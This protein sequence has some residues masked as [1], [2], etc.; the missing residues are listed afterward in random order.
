MLIIIGPID[1]LTPSFAIHYSINDAL[2]W[3]WLLIAERENIVRNKL[4]FLVRSVFEADIDFL[5]ALSSTRT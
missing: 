2:H 1:P 3:V 4:L 5:F